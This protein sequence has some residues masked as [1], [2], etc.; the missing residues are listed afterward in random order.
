MGKDD[1]AQYHKPTRRKW[2][3]DY[4]QDRDP[5]NMIFQEINDLWT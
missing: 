4:H 3:D 5:S 2:R 1:G